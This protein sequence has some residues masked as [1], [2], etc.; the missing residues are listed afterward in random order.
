MKAL[1]LFFWIIITLF[2]A[3][4]AVSVILLIYGFRPVLPSSTIIDYSAAG[5]ITDWA[6]VVVAVLI[7]MTLIYIK[8]R[9]KSN[10]ESSNEKF[11]TELNNF[12]EAYTEKV[13]DIGKA[14]DLLINAL[15][16][17]AKKKTVI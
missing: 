6:G 10:V 15:A 3:V 14:F 12:K 4:G 13:D 1:K 16:P 9:V 8:K 17:E 5:S 2:A 11:L 7:P